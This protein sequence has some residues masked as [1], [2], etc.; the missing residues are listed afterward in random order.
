MSSLLRIT[1][2]VFFLP[3]SSYAQQ[4]TDA[5]VLEHIRSITVQVRVKV[6]YAVAGT[7]TYVRQ[8]D[9]ALGS[10]FIVDSAHHIVTA[11]HVI[12]AFDKMHDQ[13]VASFRDLDGPIDPASVKT[14]LVIGF[15][16]P[17]YVDLKLRSFF[18]WEFCH[19]TRNSPET[20]QEGRGYPA[21]LRS[22][23]NFDDSN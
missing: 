1:L 19:G 23:A 10:G 12:E 18:L 20:R 5:T 15:P 4:P 2:A 17:Q 6:S 16:A 9:F 8:K 21:S 13:F 14:N 3:L 11:L 7:P 22:S